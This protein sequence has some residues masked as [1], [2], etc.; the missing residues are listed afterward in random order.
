M[1]IN[2]KIRKINKNTRELIHT[3]ILV[4]VFIFFC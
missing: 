3:S 1:V 4:A 2:F